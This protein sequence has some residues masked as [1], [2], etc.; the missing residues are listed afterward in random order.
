MPSAPAPLH[1]AL[2]RPSVVCPARMRLCSVSASTTTAHAAV[3]LVHSFVCWFCGTGFH[4]IMDNVII[5][6]ELSSSSLHN[7]VCHFE[8]I[9]FPDSDPHL[10]WSARQ[11]RNPSVVR[12]IPDSS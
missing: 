11:M 10:K 6:T 5:A 7:H 3:Y 1:L 8:R 2:V 9:T 12:R 4:F